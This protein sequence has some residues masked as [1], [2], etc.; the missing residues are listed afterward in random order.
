MAAID[1]A[2]A[3]WIDGSTSKRRLQ[4]SLKRSSNFD[5]SVAATRLQELFKVPLQPQQLAV[6][7]VFL[8]LT[9]SKATADPQIIMKAAAEHIETLVGVPSRDTEVAVQR[10]FDDALVSRFVDVLTLNV[11]RHWHN[12]MLQATRSKVVLYAIDHDQSGDARTTDAWQFPFE[13]LDNH[14]IPKSIVARVEGAVRAS[15]DT[16]VQQRFAKA[17]GILGKGPTT[18]KQLIQQRSPDLKFMY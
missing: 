2:V 14:D 17:R 16:H 1:S 8:T 6:I 4:L 3:M 15:D 11:D 5:W 12:F 10:L 18:I 13:L 9:K 7:I